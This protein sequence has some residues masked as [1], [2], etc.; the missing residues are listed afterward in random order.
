MLILQI[1]FDDV[2]FSYKIYENI[3][4][5]EQIVTKDIFPMSVVEVKVYPSKIVGFSIDDDVITPDVP[6][7]FTTI[8]QVLNAGNG[9]IET[10][11]KA[12]KMIEKII[13]VI[14]IKI[15]QGL[16]KGFSVNHI[17]DTDD[18]A[19]FVRNG[20]A[21]HKMGMPPDKFQDSSLFFGTAETLEFDITHF[22]SEFFVK[23]QFY[24]FLRIC[25]QLDGSTHPVFGL[26]IQSET[27][28]FGILPNQIRPIFKYQ[29]ITVFHS[30]KI[31]GIGM[32]MK[33]MGFAE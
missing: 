12:R 5:P 10:F 18:I 32:D 23:H 20:Y 1:G 11:Q 19:F 9:F 15:V 2:T 29:D 27:A 8:M 17:E 22:G 3:A 31:T 21:L 26:I 13:M 25:I 24:E 7:F 16:D 14:F 33:A 28:F 30:K 4:Q 6:V